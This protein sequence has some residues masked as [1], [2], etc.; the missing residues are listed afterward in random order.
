MKIKNVK[1]IVTCP[2]R[3]YVLVKIETDEGLYGV[4]D[5]TLA[6]RELAVASLLENH[7]APLLLERDPEQVEDAWQYIFRGTYWRGGP[8]SMTA[9]AGIDM[10]LWDI[11]GKRAGVPVYNLLGGQ[12]RDKV[13][14]YSHAIGKDSQEVEESVRERME[15][16]FK[17]IRVVPGVSRTGEGGRRSVAMFPKGDPL[18][19][20][21]IFE[22]RPYLQMIPQLFDH[23]R[24]KVGW[25]VEFIFD[26]HERLTPVEAAQLAKD[27][28]P[29]RLFYLED[30]VRPEHKE[31]FRVVRQHSTT[32]LATGEHFFT[33]WDCLPLI[34]EQLIDYIRCDLAHVGGITEAKKIAAIAE[35]YYVKTAWHGSADIGPIAHA[36]NVHVDMAVPNFG[37]QECPL[38]PELVTQVVSG[39]PRVVDG[40]AVLSEAP[41]LGCDIDEAL[42]ARY[43]YERGYL[44]VVRRR[45]GSVHDW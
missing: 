9:L 45:D 4:G 20:V 29:Y 38:I 27:L 19:R 10:A 8:I 23:L 34:T 15:R 5:A 33:K 24:S 32:P 14:C 28:E 43:P 44:P 21:E 18:P 39:M 16:G 26:A 3:N 31:S 42:A 25:E 11:K 37:V 17:V 40:Y 41:G 6:G 22:P 12:C 36:A 7:L 30:A 13:L 35:A 1:V 2:G